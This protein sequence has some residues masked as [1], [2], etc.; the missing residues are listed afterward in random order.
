MSWKPSN[1]SKEEKINKH[2]SERSNS[3]KSECRD[4]HWRSRGRKPNV[5]IYYAN[6]QK[7]GTKCFFERNC[8]NADTRLIV[9]TLGKS[10]SGANIKV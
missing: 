4:R 6:L 8:S 5:Y 7:F 9:K 10:H 3:G 1:S 2:D